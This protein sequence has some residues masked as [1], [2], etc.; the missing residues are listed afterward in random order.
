M[1]F[2]G[3]RAFIVLLALVAPVMELTPFYQSHQ[4]ETVR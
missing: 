3:I 4:F 2:R 1:K